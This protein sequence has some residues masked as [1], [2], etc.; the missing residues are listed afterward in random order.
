MASPFEMAHRTVY[1]VRKNCFF[2]SGQKMSQAIS[3]FVYLYSKKFD[4][5]P[6][7]AAGEVGLLCLPQQAGLLQGLPSSH[8]EAR[9]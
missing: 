4:A 8:L 5:L 3:L 9:P 6:Q 1:R 7:L 2:R